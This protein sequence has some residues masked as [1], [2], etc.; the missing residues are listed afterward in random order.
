MEQIEKLKFQQDV[1]TG[2]TYFDTIRMHKE[3]Q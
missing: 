3:K 1:T 2:M